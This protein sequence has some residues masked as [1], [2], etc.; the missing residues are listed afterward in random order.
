MQFKET[1]IKNEVYSYCFDNLIKAK[2][3]ET[4]SFLIHNKNY[5][6][7]VIYFARMIMESR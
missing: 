2:K 4:K 1:S 7:L 3:L 6:N 5:R